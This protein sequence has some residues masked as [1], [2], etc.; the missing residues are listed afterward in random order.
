MLKSMLRLRR[1]AGALASCSVIAISLA[2]AG[3]RAGA[4]SNFPDVPK[5]HWAYS[6]VLELKQ[7]GI[8]I[9]Y[10][11]GTFNGIVPK[12]VPHPKPVYDQS[13]PE[14][15]LTSF[16][17]ALKSA[18][19]EGL[20]S[21]VTEREYISIPVESRMFGYRNLNK[22][23]RS[24]GKRLSEYQAYVNEKTVSGDSVNSTIVFQSMRYPTDFQVSM[25][26]DEENLE[27]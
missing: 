19:L 21:I 11:N 1:T 16:E 6:A 24:L 3:T 9:G 18:D 10:P 14:N 7:K 2:V 17:R 15:C 26:K 27:S 25:K 8:L 5:D 22:Y 4:Q 23:L 13:T 12:G 20:K